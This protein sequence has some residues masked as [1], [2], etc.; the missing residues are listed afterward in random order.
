MNASDVE[1]SA[2]PAAEL[3]TGPAAE[4]ST[5]PV[6]RPPTGDDA[7]SRTGHDAMPDAMPPAGTSGRLAVL[8]AV[9]LAP[10][11]NADP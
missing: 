4:P 11:F 10:T 6:G 2:E 3:S 9:E 7:A 8:D 5:G 1:P